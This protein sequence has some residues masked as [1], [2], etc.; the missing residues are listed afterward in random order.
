MGQDHSRSRHGV[1]DRPA[2]HLGGTA[3]TLLGVPTASLLSGGSPRLSLSASPSS[4]NVPRSM[5]WRGLGARGSVNCC[6]LSAGG[7]PGEQSCF[8]SAEGAPGECTEESPEAVLA[9]PQEEALLEPVQVA[10]LPQEPL[11]PVFVETLSGALR[12]DLEVEPTESVSLSPRK[13]LRNAFAVLGSFPLKCLFPF[14]CLPGP[15]RSGGQFI[16]TAHSK[17]YT[18]PHLVPLLTLLELVVLC[19]RFA[20]MSRPLSVVSS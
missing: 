13:L 9:F 6:F 10:S 8:L 12:R 3:S 18:V 5:R 19:G 17:C 15:G 16:R 2:S 7:A 1:D 4:W 14:C 20:A 11:E